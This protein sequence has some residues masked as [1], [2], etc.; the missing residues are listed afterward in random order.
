MQTSENDQQG[1]YL[2]QL[3]SDACGIA[4]I[5]HLENKGSNDI[6]HDGLTM[7]EKMEHRGACGFEENTGDGAGLP[8]KF[9]MSFFKDTFSKIT[10]YC[11]LPELT[12]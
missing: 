4:M 2:P 5:A 10:S 7:L 9:H 1:L 3:E 12:V 8:A 6:I 11:H